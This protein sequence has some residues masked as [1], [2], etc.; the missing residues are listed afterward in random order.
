L[1]D[2][3]GYVAHFRLAWAGSVVPISKEKKKKRG[4]EG[5]RKGGREGRRKGG[6]EEGDWPTLEVQTL[7]HCSGSATSI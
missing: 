1:G 4:R 5:R 2:S 6:R 3:L 7:V